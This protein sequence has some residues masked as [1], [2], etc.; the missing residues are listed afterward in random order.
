MISLWPANF[1]LPLPDR[2][3]PVAVHVYVDKTI[4]WFPRRRNP[5][6]V[7]W[8]RQHCET[9]IDTDDVRDLAWLREHHRDLYEYC[10][11]R[12]R[13]TLSS[14][15]RQDF[16]HSV[17]LFQPG[18]GALKWV[19]QRVH[20]LTYVELANDL[21]YPTYGAAQHADDFMDAH[22]IKKHHRGNN[23]YKGA[24]RYTNSRK[25]PNNMVVYADK[26]SRITGEPCC[27][28]EWRML[29]RAALKAAG[30]SSAADLVVFNHREFW[31]RRLVIGQLDLQRLGRADYHR[32]LKQRL[33]GRQQRRRNWIQECGTSRKHRVDLFFS[34]GR[35]LLAG[36]PRPPT[37]HTR[38]VVC[39]VQD[40]ID[41]LRGKIR[42]RDYVTMFDNSSLLPD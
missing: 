32:K 20:H 24:S 38:S 41:A 16:E 25:S 21:V 35:A 27:H 26:R 34:R 2:I 9:L 8:L 4:V 5:F 13:L 10:G 31:Q 30:I 3:K 37:P 39:S 14:P 29:G 23:R 6:D 33:G 1:V 40:V 36:L 11:R 17:I 28:L 22:L 42:A 19:G 15:R 18:D 12:K 7:R